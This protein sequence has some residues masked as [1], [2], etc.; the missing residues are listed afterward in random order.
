M[1]RYAWLE[2]ILIALVGGAGSW[3]VA[4]QWGWL[5]LL[6]AALT[7]ALLSFY[8]DFPRSI[9]PGATLLLSPADGKIMSVERD[10]TSLEGGRELRICIFLSVFNCHVNRSPCAATVKEIVY[11]PGMSL[12]AMRPDATLKNENNLIVLTPSDPLPGPIRV[13]Q[14]AGLLAKRIVCAVPVGQRLASGERVGMIKLGSQTELRAPDDARWQ[15][16]VVAGQ[17][18]KAGVTVLAEWRG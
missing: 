2:V 4:H 3:A 17:S 5:A 6:P 10:W 11:T 9:P 14:I 15:V 7:L 16:R 18:V 13:R 8:R 1:A 12:N